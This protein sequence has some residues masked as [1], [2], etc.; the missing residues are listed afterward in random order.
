MTKPQLSQE[1]LETFVGVSE[2]LL[3]A[4][5]LSGSAVGETIKLVV[6]GIRFLAS[7][8]RLELVE[9]TATERHEMT[10]EE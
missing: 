10:V 7:L 6:G 1:D 3:T 5:G 9:V 2:T 8:G 4:T